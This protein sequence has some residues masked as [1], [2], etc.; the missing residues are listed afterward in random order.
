[1]T[2]LFF[3]LSLSSTYLTVGVLFVVLPLVV[4]T[5]FAVWFLLTQG[6][7]AIADAKQKGLDAG[8]GVKSEIF[9]VVIGPWFLFFL[10]TM[11]GGLV[12][13]QCCVVVWR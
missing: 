5:V 8:T 7:T 2:D 1:M 13:C 10:I 3:A 9:V 12:L 11:G 4:N 6:R